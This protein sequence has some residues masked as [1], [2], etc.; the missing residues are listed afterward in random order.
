MAME[1]E[2]EDRYEAENIIFEKLQIDAVKLIEGSE[3]NHNYNMSKEES[4]TVD[5]LKSIFGMR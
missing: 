1:I 4:H 3:P 2:A 5:N